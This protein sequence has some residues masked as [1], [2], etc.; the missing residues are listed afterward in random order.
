MAQSGKQRRSKVETPFSGPGAQYRQ[1]CCNT[2]AATAGRL[3]GKWPD[4][5]GFSLAAVVVTIAVQAAQQRFLYG[6]WD[7]N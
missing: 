3:V 2:S 4:A 1:P 5:A 6:N 7:T